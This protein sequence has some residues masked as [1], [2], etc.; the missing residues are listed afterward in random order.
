L[1]IQAGLAGL[2][3]A[4]AGAVAAVIAVVGALAIGGFFFFQYGLGLAP[5]PLCL[6]QRIPYYISVPL[7]GLLWLGANHGAAR[8]V[9]VA[10]FAVIAAAMLW[11]SGIAVYHAGIEWQFWTGPADCTGP[12]TDLR[13][14]GGL[15]NQLQSIS[16][17]RCDVAAWRLFGL[18]LAGWNV[19]LSLAL[20]ALSAW[21]CR[22]ALARPADQ[23]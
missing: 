15:L 23:R 4:D 14:P 6:E 5:C 2:K 21:G 20:A 17:V 12:L 19:P 3:R 9:L 13:G 18:S 11:N 10:G 7:A 8:K 22:G 16:L 1:D